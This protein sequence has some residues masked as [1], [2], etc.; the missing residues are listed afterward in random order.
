M[1][2]RYHCGMPDR[3]Q[4]IGAN[5]R[6]LRGGRSQDSVATSMALTGGWSTWRRQTLIKIERGERPLRLAEAVTLSAIFGCTLD[7]LV[8]ERD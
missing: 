5:V 2:K 4:L 8:A 7:D 1:P 6:R 3:D